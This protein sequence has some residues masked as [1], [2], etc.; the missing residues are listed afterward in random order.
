MMREAVAK[1]G[2]LPSDEW[3]RQRQETDE[4]IK[5]QQK[6]KERVSVTEDPLIHNS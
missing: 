4:E 6:S 2:C 3:R 1:N 5:I